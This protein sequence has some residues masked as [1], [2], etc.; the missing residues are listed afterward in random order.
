VIL[1]TIRY[2]GVNKQLWQNMSK[3]IIDI[4]TGFSIL[5]F[6]WYI[7]VM[8][9]I[10]DKALLPSPLKVAGAVMELIKEGTLLEHFIVSFQRFLAGYIAAVV[11]GVALGLFLGWF[12]SIWNIVDPVVQVIRPVSPIAWLPFVVLLFGIGNLPAIVIIFI[13]AFFPILLSTVSSIG[14]IDPTYF[15]V[16]RNFGIRQPHILTKI[17][18]PAAF[19]YITIGLHIGVGTGWI[20]LVAGEM[21]GAQSGLGFLIIDS[22]NNLRAD[23]LIAA[24]IFIGLSGLLL[25]KLLFV[26]ERWIGKNWGITTAYTGV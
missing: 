14:K 22:R 20:F 5:I 3:K 9:G 25:D 17:V 15:K 2:L 1:L 10:Y 12:R 7:V 11:F 6:V 18:F 26:L 4:A 23:L 19:P 13:A 24:I 16:A 21:I 8:S